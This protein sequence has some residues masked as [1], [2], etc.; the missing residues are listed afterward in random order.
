M[1]S[2]TPGRVFRSIRSCSETFVEQEIEFF[3]GSLLFLF[4]EFKH[5][6]C[7]F[8]IAVSHFCLNAVSKFLHLL[9]SNTISAY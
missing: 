2:G 8:W 6:V 7:Y 3:I 4:P 1:H 5:L 9:V